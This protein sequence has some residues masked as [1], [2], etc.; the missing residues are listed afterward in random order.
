MSHEDFEHVKKE[1]NGEDNNKTNF[2]FRLMIYKKMFLHCDWSI[3]VQLISNR[4]AKDCYNSAK[5]CNNRRTNQISDGKT[6]MQIF[7][8]IKTIKS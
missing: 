7:L 8:T 6:G 2:V 3:S 5:I 4:S 1:Y